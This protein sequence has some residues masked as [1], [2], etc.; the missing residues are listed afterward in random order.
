MSHPLIEADTFDAAV[1]VP[2][3][4][5]TDYP[6]TVPLG[7][8][9][10][11]NRT[12]WLADTLG[13]AAGTTTVLDNT[14]T[15]VFDAANF[16]VPLS[17][18]AGLIYTL[19]Y[20]LVSTI[21]YVRQYLWAGAQGSRVMAVPMDPT[22]EGDGAGNWQ[23]PG[24]AIIVGGPFFSTS[25]TAGRWWW[26]QFAIPTGAPELY[27]HVPGLPPQGTILSFSLTIKGAGGHG[28]LPT[29][30]PTLGLYK[31]L[32][33]GATTQ[34]ASINDASA[35]TTQ[36]QLEHSLQASGLSEPL[37]AN[38]TYFFKFTGEAGT[39]KQ[40]LLQLFECNIGIGP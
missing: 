39:N 27:W 1:T 4:L 29:T 22:R 35:N 32:P 31:Q 16:S 8:G 30:M 14:N 2:D 6:T 5:D 21:R 23:P 25:A 20:Q 11:A 37:V 38:T 33:S 40:T 36:Y 13:G 24:T 34:I 10:L 7:M 28:G 26:Y 17:T 19:A 3:V 9:A 18:R 12:R 15:G